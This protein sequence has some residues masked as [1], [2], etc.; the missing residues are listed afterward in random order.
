M[1][2]VKNPDTYRLVVCEK[3]SVAQAVA[4]V[5]GA[6]KRCD[7]CLEGGGFLVSWCVGH[8]AGLAAADAY[9]AR[10]SRWARED[11]PILPQEWRYTVFPATRKQFDIL[12]KL[13]ERPD[14][15]EIIEATDVG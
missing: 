6:G 14:V 11:L 2:N 8:L 3:P 7:G 10:Y 15:S 12:K 5:I 13:M 9:D 1:E 4:K